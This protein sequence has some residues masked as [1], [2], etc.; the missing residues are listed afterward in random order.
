MSN[1]IFKKLGLLFLVLVLSVVMAACSEDETASTD[2]N[3]DTD[4]GSANTDTE[5]SSGLSGE[6][7]VWAHPYTD[8]STG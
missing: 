2:A 6:I 4:N 8:G 1:T 7:T 5:E 3:T